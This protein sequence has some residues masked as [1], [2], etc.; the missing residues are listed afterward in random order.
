MAIGFLKPPSASLV[1]MTL[2][3]I[4]QIW[5]GFAPTSLPE[6]G[7]ASPRS[8]WYQLS[9]LASAVLL[10]PGR[11]IFHLARHRVRGTK[12]EK[13]LLLNWMGLRPGPVVTN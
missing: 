1:Y 6:L 4:A 11:Y 12:I 5:L 9:Q 13:P 2:R 8:R 10:K 7:R 3:N